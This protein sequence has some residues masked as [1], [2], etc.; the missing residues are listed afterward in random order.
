MIVKADVPVMPRFSAVRRCNS[1]HHKQRSGFQNL[2]GFLHLRS[3]K[4][5]SALELLYHEL[6]V[7]S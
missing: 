6:V 2:S 5:R 1:P 3:S 4:T 7:N